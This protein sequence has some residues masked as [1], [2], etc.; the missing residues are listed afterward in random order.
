MIRGIQCFIRI[1][2]VDKQI[3]KHRDE[4]ETFL[5]IARDHAPGYIISH[6]LMIRSEQGSKLALRATAIE[7]LVPFD[8]LDIL[9]DLK[10]CRRRI[11]LQ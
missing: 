7:L 5:L 11:L 1:I 3:S 6:L 8:K 4:E 10:P 9:Q 2:S